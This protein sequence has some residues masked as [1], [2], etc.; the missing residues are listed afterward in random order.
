ML[1]LLKMLIVA[2]LS[3]L[4]VAT[5][6]TPYTFA[7]SGTTDTVLTA[8][9][10]MPHDLGEIVA[11][12]RTVL[13]DKNGKQFGQL[14]SENRVNVTLED[15]NPVVVQALLDT[16][17]ANFYTHG[18]LDVKGFLR[19]TYKNATSDS[20]QGASTISQQLVENLRVMAA[21]SDKERSAAKAN[22]LPGKLQ[23]LRYATEL[24]RNYT[25]DEILIQYLNTVYLG[26]GA[27]GIDAAAQRYFSTTA[28]NLTVD[29]SAT[30]IAML[31]SPMVFDPIDFPAESRLR[32]DVVM[33]RMVV[34]KHLTQTEYDT[35]RMVPTELQL[36][37]P[38]SGCE[39]STYPYYCALLIRHILVSPEFGKTAKDRETFLAQGGLTITT[40][41]DPKVMS[42]AQ[43]AV[44]RALGRTNRVAAGSA[45]I[46]PGT[47]RLLGIAQNRTFGKGRGKTEIV[48]PATT[49][50][51]PGST[52]KPITLATAFEQGISTRVRYNT[53]SPLRV[54]GLDSP[55]SG[56]KNDDSQGHGSLD[57]YGATKGSVNT[58][59]VQLVRDV[60]V[61]NV[62]TMARRLGMYSMPTDLNGREGSITLGAY[63]TSPVQLATVYA[64]F[65]ARGVKCDPVL[66]L[67][68]TIN[69]TGKTLKVPD[70]D[71]H[72]AILPN[73]A[74]T[75][76][77]VLQETFK[78]GGTASK[79]T[80]AN[81][82]KAGGKT[83]TTNSNAATWFSGFTPQAAMSVWVGD[84][85][86]GNRYPVQNI[87]AYGTFYGTVW[88]GT[89][90]GPIWQE[91][92]NKI[93]RGLK[94]RWLP[95][96]TG[97]SSS[98]T[99]RL[100]PAVGGM[101]LDEAVTLLQEQGF[102]LALNPKNA[103]PS[104]SIQQP[105]FVYSQTPT[106]GGTT[107]HGTKVTLTLTAGSPTN[108][109]LKA[110]K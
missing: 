2:P 78:S 94:K 73:I 8:W 102:V 18:S 61:K 105:G 109:I 3:G 19:A 68:A 43:K 98:L 29:Q 66:I 107:G 56:Y 83:G 104:A 76:A 40:A 62:A 97:V 22:S 55:P 17:D 63:E 72:Q 33:K 81:G 96:P 5:S 1:A 42:A 14:F 92:M 82:R 79:V 58:W 86:G 10:D 46:Q 9:E 65:A 91:T 54:N 70:G 24:E 71:C 95:S 74:D 23:E 21:T 38:R 69:M 27:Y 4:L 35:L 93:H 11:K 25:K 85:R 108:I 59:F 15:I 7:F 64:T 37:T 89:V 26:N 103:K 13:L 39:A 75:V 50:F 106:A 34:K 90:A 32:R 31:K 16:E 20:M 110:T 52:F 47:G 51:Q 99:S 53:P 88:G 41:L 60:G 36:S 67:K 30:L 101:K 6:L 87:R 49:Q 100:V 57:A 28:K 44:D 48:L 77:D 84:P 80:L 12:Q 45:I